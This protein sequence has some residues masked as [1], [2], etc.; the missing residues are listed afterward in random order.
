MW[1]LI[2]RRPAAAALCAVVLI[3]GVTGLIG[4]SWYSASLRNVQ[5]S[6]DRFRVSARDQEAL[7]LREEMR[8]RRYAYAADIGTAFAAWQHIPQAVELLARH[9]PA[10]GEEDHRSFVWYF[11][12]RHYRSELHRLD[13]GGGEVDLLACSFNSNRLA[14]A[15]GKGT[16]RLWDLEKGRVVDDLDGDRRHRQRRHVIG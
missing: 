3:A 6:N 2:R 15:D 12:E 1:R 16:V 4:V 13:A 9:R 14:S 8:V 11:L 5:A 10:K 7:A